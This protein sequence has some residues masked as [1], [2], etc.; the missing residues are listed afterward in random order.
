MGDGNTHEDSRTLS[1]LRLWG[2]ENSTRT[3]TVETERK[4]E[5]KGRRIG[6]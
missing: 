1:F 6:S 2:I 4:E 5:V 3:L